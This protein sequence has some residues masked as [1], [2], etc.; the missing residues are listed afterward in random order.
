MTKKSACRR[1]MA[2]V[3]SLALLTACGG[4]GA[5][6]AGGGL[7]PPIGFPPPVAVTHRMDVASPAPVVSRRSLRAST[8]PTAAARTSHR[9]RRSRSRPRRRRGRCSAVGAARA[10]AMPAPAPCAWTPRSP[11]RPVRRRTAGGRLGR[12]GHAVRR[13][14]QLAEGGGRC[15]RARAGRVA[16]TRGQFADGQAV[17]QPLPTRRRLEHAAA[18]RGQQRCGARRPCRHRQAERPCRRGVDAVELGNGL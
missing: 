9:A 7:L 12:C 13:R 2:C 4:G 8:A 6:G 1:W 18:P 11:S 14:S 17:G 3:W 16:S 15:A 10:A 5:G